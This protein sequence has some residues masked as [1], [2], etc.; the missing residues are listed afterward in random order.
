MQGMPHDDIAAEFGYANRGTA[1][2]VVNKA[3]TERVDG[4]VEEY[5][6]MELARL[7]AL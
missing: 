4:A 2:R 1:W 5:R 6:Q 3:L 7:D